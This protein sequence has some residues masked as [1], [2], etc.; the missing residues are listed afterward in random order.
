MVEGFIIIYSATKYK[1]GLSGNPKK[2]V[3]VRHYSPAHIIFYLVTFLDPALLF[4][5]F[6]FGLRLDHRLGS[7]VFFNF[8]QI[9]CLVRIFIMILIFLNILLNISIILFYFIVFRFGCY[10]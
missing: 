7:F 1:M 3:C 2:R 10:T 4:Y 8:D 6:I 5:F 9:H